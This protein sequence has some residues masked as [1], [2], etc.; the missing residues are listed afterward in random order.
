MMMRELKLQLMLQSLVVV[1][2][3]SVNPD[4]YPLN[5]KV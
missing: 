2:T 1:L 5:K 4:S 3:L